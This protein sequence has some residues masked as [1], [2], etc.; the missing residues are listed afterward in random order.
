MSESVE[1]DSSQIEVWASKIGFPP[2]IE[3]YVGPSDTGMYMPKD[4]YV[5]F[6]QIRFTRNVSTTK[7]RAV[8]TSLARCI[9]YFDLYQR[10]FVHRP[11]GGPD[12]C[13]PGFEL[14]ESGEY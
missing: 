3:I 10:R 1:W 9:Q 5:T 7:R 2:I 14:P 13:G 11:H 12:R 8:A 6:F 4:G